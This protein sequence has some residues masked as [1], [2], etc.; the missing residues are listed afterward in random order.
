MLTDQ[1]DIRN[2][3]MIGTICRK[4]NIG[5]ISRVL[6]KYSPKPWE[7]FTIN[8]TSQRSK[9]APRSHVIEPTTSRD[10]VQALRDFST[11]RR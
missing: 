10:F 1:K 9:P 7:K 4:D 8:F 6:Q 11:F 3:P 2:R 5:I